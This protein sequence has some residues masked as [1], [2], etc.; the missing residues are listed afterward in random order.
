MYYVSML[1]P[2]EACDCEVE[3]DQMRP[4]PSTELRMLGFTVVLMKSEHLPDTDAVDK[5]GIL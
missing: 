1:S 3:C 2:V 4:H 5:C